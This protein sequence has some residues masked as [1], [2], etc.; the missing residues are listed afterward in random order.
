[1]PFEFKRLEIPDVILVEAKQFLDN[2]G[3]FEEIYKRSDF[4]PHIPCNFVQVNHSFSKKGVLRGL[5]F[6]LK[7]VPQGKLVTVTS[8]KIFD[9]AVDL[10]KNSPYYKKWVSVILTPSK[11]L[12]IPV[13]FAHG[14]LA[15]EE[16]HVVYMVTREFSKEHD[17]GIRYD[18][19]EIN[20]KWPIDSEIIVSDKDRNLPYLKDAKINFEYGDDLC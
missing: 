4:E 13:G 11:L 10:R 1:M 15:L 19:P 7:P 12:W 5:H 14:F 16:S 6:Q 3:Y 8:G 2:R 20:V 17:G 9:V 18:D